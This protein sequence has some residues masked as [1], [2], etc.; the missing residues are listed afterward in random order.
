MLQFPLNIKS[1]YIFLINKLFIKTIL[2]KHFLCVH[3]FAYLG[4]PYDT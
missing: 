2:I 4:F 3:I 1:T